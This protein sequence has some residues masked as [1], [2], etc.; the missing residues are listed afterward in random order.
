MITMC[1]R[2]ISFWLLILITIA[3]GGCA[4]SDPKEFGIYLL[5]NEMPADKF[6]AADLNNLELSDQPVISMADIIS[7]S[8]TTHAINL[9]NE[10]YQR[11]QDLFLL[12][13]DVD[14]IPFVI[15]VDGEPIY[16]GAF[17]TPASSLI[18]DGV[19]IMEPFAEDTTTIRLELGYPS[20]EFVS[21]IDPRSDVR[22]MEALETA[23]KLR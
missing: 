9:N 5:S 20:T 6:L 1:F 4:V 3:A 15:S 8:Q 11:I 23:G 12:P 10:A 14:G 18:F 19:T 7:Y 22:I 2:R 17:W 21:G 16:G 13:V